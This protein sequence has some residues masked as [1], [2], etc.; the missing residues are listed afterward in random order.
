MGPLDYIIMHRLRHRFY[1]ANGLVNPGGTVDHDGPLNPNSETPI[2]A[3]LDGTS[4]TIMYMEDG[5]RPNWFVLGADQGTIL[6][7]PEGYGWTDPDGGAGSMDGTDATTGAINGGS[8]TGRCIMNCNND[9]E[10]YSMHSGGM[11]ICMADGSV[12]F[13]QSN[14]SAATFAALLTARLGDV[15]GSDF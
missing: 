3:I 14:I 6:P 9:S 10:P 8:G 15:V 7:R 12:R 11:N 4:N 5:G 1:T 2:N 13:I